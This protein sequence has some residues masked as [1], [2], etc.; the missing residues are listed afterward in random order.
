ML[1]IQWGFARFLFF[2][3]FV[4]AVFSIRLNNFG[5]N[6]VPILEILLKKLGTCDVQIIHN[7]PE[8][9][10]DWNNM[11]T[12]VKVVNGIDKLND[13]QF[14]IN[15]H[16]SRAATHCKF[17]ILISGDTIRATGSK[18]Y[19]ENIYDWIQ[20]AY[21]GHVYYPPTSETLEGVDYIRWR[22]AVVAIVI[23]KPDR[24]LHD[25]VYVWAGKEQKISVLFIL[26]ENQLKLCDW[27]R[28]GF[29]MSTPSPN[30]NGQTSCNEYRNLSLK[31]LSVFDITN[32][33]APQSRGWCYELSDLQYKYYSTLDMEA[34]KVKNP[35]K[36]RVDYSQMK[37]IL[38][39]IFTA[40]NETLYFPPNCPSIDCWLTN[41]H[42]FY[43]SPHRVNLIVTGDLGFEF[44]FYLTPFKPG[45]WLTLILS[46]I[47]IIVIIISYTCFAGLTN[48]S[49]SVVLFVFA[50][51]F[52][53]SGHQPGNVERIS[54]LRLILG[55][56]CLVSV[57]LTN[58]Y[59]GVMITELNAPH[60]SLRPNLF[61]D[62]RCESIPKFDLSNI[63]NST[64]YYGSW[65]YEIASS[66][67]VYGEG[68]TKHKYD[69]IEWYLQVLLKENYRPEEELGIGLNQPN[70]IYEVENPF[71]LKACFKLLSFPKIHLSGVAHLPEFLQHLYDNVHNNILLGFKNMTALDMQRI[72]FF[73]PRHI[74]HLR[75]LQHSHPNQT[76]LEV[77]S[78]L[79][80]ELIQCGKTVFIADSDNID[81]ELDFLRKYYPA[82]RFYKG[83]EIFDH[84]DFHWEVIQYGASKVPSYLRALLESGIYRRLRIEEIN[85]KYLGRKPLERGLQSSLPVQLDGAISTLFILCSG[86]A[87]FAMLVF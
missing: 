63:D 68:Q 16:K 74:H 47:I 60:N 48:T 26:Q 49:F 41:E 1:I 15:I 69:R 52:E 31:N 55:P 70:N 19:D 13:T 8:S 22:N 6:V 77:Q 24:E 14:R 32:K 83:K 50:T 46:L 21:F 82:K 28:I 61:D 34:E 12:P 72:N 30:Q 54:F 23:L 4:H 20:A 76:F 87:V 79:E 11:N 85:Q 81:A 62:L 29:D 78:H 9:N 25:K 51:V 39:I 35:F 66:R 3:L 17:A 58:C 75:S 45:L 43:I 36:H 73:D 86:I 37:I 84:I 18:D 64:L 65:L 56:W 7:V 10:V 53:E 57:I 67:P 38:G 44:K 71:A 42:T 80:K 33:F 59:S 2:I 5:T 27:F 40:A